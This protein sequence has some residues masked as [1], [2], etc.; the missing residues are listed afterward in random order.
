MC[1]RDS[2]LCVCVCLS[3][4]VCVHMCVYMHVYLRVGVFVHLFVPSDM[5]APFAVFMGRTMV[6]L[7][8][9]LLICDGLLVIGFYKGSRKMTLE[10]ASHRTSSAVKLHY[11][12]FCHVGT[13]GKTI[14]VF[15]QQ[16]QHSKDH[17]FYNLSMETYTMLF[18]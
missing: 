12:Y 3:Q 11:R 13:Q 15:I 10:T 17:I 4:C 2:V 7:R 18:F 8:R 1:I 5:F 6:G 9:I 14:Y 16:K